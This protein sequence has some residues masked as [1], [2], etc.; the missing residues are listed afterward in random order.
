MNKEASS[1]VVNMVKPD[2]NEVTIVKPETTDSKQVSTELEDQPKSSQ[3]LTEVAE[4][5]GLTRD[6][7]IEKV[8]H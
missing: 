8:S 3:A 5:Y 7:R 1:L 6:Y 4:P 2:S